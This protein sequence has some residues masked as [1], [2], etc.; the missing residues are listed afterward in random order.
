MWKAATG[1][2]DGFGVTLV[3][4][5]EQAQALPNGECLA[6]ALVDLDLEVAV[7]VARSRSGETAVFPVTD[8]DFHPTSNQV[9]FVVVTTRLSTALAAAGADIAVRP[10]AAPVWS[11]SSP[12]SAG[13]TIVTSSTPATARAT[14]VVTASFRFD[15]GSGVGSCGVMILL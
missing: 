10:S 7:Q 14:A 8:M 2:Y 9:D 3:R 5:E 15:G 6:E 13:S 12:Y 11:G 4:T 1:G